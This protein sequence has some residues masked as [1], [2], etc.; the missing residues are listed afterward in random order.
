VRSI[1]TICPNRDRY[2]SSL[3]LV[4]LA[5]A[6]HKHLRL[7]ARDHA[8]SQS[9][10]YGIISAGVYFIISTLLFWNLLGAYVFKQYPPSFTSLTMS[11][12]TLMLQTISYSLYLSLG[13]GIFAS[14][15]GWSF[16]DGVYWADYTLLTIGL[17]SDFPLKKTLSKGLL[18]PYTAIG[19]I[20][21]GLV[22]DSVRVL[23]LEREK[24]HRRAIE[25]ERQKLLKKLDLSDYDCKH[26]F[27]LMRKVQDEAEKRR[28]WW[29]LGSSFTAFLVVW[30]GGAMVF[31]LSE[32]PQS[33]GF[34]EALYFTYISLLTIGYGDY[35]PQSNFG[36]PFFV[37]WSLIAIPTVTILISTM[38]STVVEWVKEGTLW[39]G[40]KTIL[41]ERHGK[42]SGF[43]SPATVRE[44]ATEEE[45]EEQEQEQDVEE[46]GVKEDMEQLGHVVQ[47]Q[48]GEKVEEDHGHHHPHLGALIAREISCLSKDIGRKPPKKY[49]WDAW[50]R[51]LELLGE[52][53]EEHDNKW[54]WLGHSGPLLS[55]VTETEWILEKMCERLEEVLVKK[56]DS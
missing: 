22:V 38:G 16:V 42:A 55:G 32:K 14:I 45:G 48:A 1:H 13:A 3:L 39:L 7:P 29:G 40:R 36:K 49:E 46:L 5:V 50:K 25:K 21:I 10:Y 30:L 44:E 19:I 12:R 20:M 17:G 37:I 53:E 35:Y 31:M 33:W 28:R 47:A 18:I 9:Y 26:E 23:L 2:I 56:K 27:E 15:E 4:S 11:Q 24:V 52:W 43:L 41:P 8:F 54:R 51:F 6:A 34:F